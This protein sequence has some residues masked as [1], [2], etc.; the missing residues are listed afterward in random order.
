MQRL[1]ELKKKLPQSTKGGKGP[2]RSAVQKQFEP[3]KET[4][5]EKITLEDVSESLK[6]CRVD[7][8]GYL[9]NVPDDQVGHF[10]AGD[11]YVIFCQYKVRVRMALL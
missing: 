9:A 6:I 11:S 10:Y 8:G 5:I 1:R 4:P 2:A 3:P 7:K